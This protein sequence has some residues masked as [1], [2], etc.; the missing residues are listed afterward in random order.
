MRR[1]KR[2]GRWWEARIREKFVVVEQREGKFEKKEESYR[3]LHPSCVLA[4]C[5]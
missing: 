4:A 2:E 1:E 5:L 3:P